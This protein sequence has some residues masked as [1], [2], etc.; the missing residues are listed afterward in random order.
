[1]R[2]TLGLSVLVLLT[3]HGPAASAAQAPDTAGRDDEAPER[4]G[5]PPQVALVLV[6]STPA[7]DVP[8]RQALEADVALSVER[9]PT[10]SLDEITE[11]PAQPADA[12]I[13]LILREE[14]ALLIAVD[15]TR[16]R[17]QL[18][19]FERAPAEDD[20]LAETIADAAA[21]TV[22]AIVGGA[23]VGVASDAAVKRLREL[24]TFE[25]DFY[26]A[27]WLSYE[28]SFDPSFSHGPV[29]GVS[30]DRRAGVWSSFFLELGYRFG[31][32][33]TE[34][35][36]D[37]R[38]D[39][40]Q[41]RLGVGLTSAGPIRLGGRVTAGADFV[42]A[43]VDAP[44]GFMSDPELHIDATFQLG[45]RFEVDVGS[46]VG[47]IVDAGAELALPR[48]RYVIAT[49]RGELSVEEPWL[50]RP[51]FRLGVRVF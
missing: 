42:F 7:F 24:P 33:Q 26:V 16:E 5:A 43:M 38:I 21:A 51:F 4:E 11:A 37:L 15:D 8:L 6:D 22:G 13:Y 44:E 18:R 34:A 35:G 50:V 36:V 19:T 30:L 23:P 31:S 32:S 29:L 17:V 27:A 3:T 25:R 40:F 39:R 48:Q 46:H 10:V 2:G 1:M 47:L 20:I 45:P 41:A 49:Q 9:S 12:R 28:G 14:R